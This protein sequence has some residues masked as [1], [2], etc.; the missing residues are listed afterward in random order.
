MH[1]FKVLEQSTEHPPETIAHF[2]KKNLVAFF[3]LSLLETG[4]SDTEV[5]F[6]HEF[7]IVSMRHVSPCSDYL[8]DNNRASLRPLVEGGLLSKATQ[9]KNYKCCSWLQTLA[10]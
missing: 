2:T 10:G 4:S 1:V 3:N 8:D 5:I 7:I 6:C 9:L